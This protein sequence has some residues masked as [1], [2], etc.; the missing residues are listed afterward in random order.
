MTNLQE[1]YRDRSSVEQALREGN[2]DFSYQ[3][4]T[5]LDLSGLEFLDDTDFTGSDLA[6]TDMRRVTALRAI[7]RFTNLSEFR[8]SYAD[9]TGSN[10]YSS[11][12][13][14]ADF[15]HA[16]LSDCDMCSMRLTRVTLDE[17]LLPWMPAVVDLGVRMPVYRVDQHGD[18]DLGTA[19]Q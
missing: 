10:F 19:A 4:L 17:Q 6:S 15:S 9:F 2:I 3:N 5:G 14:R 18:S 13:D 8:A 11:Q 7:F 12:A 16:N 1:D